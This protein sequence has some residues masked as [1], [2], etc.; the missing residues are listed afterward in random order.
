MCRLSEFVEGITGFSEE[1]ARRAQA[2]MFTDISEVPNKVSPS[3]GPYDSSAHARL[4]LL[5]G[6]HEGNSGA[7]DFSPI[8]VFHFRSF[9][10]GLGLFDESV[11]SL[12]PVSIH[13]NRPSIID[14][15][16]Q[17]EFGRFLK[18]LFTAGELA[19]LNGL[20]NTFLEVGWQG[21]VYHAHLHTAF[22]AIDR[23]FSPLD[24]AAPS[25]KQ[26]SER[27]AAKVES[28]AAAR[29]E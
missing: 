22:Y 2:A 24:F 26:S 14:S 10:A 17:K 23:R 9:A 28:L 1:A 4:S 12:L 8:M 11:N 7:L 13:R 16:A 29:N 3:G 6:A 25:C 15:E 27:R 18:E 21:N 20:I 19:A 5:S